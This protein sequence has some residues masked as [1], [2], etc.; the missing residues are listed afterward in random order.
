MGENFRILFDSVSRLECILQISTNNL[1]IFTNR[2]RDPFENKAL[3]LDDI[4]KCVDK[5]RYNS[6]Y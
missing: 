3:N 4:Y 2:M 6:S 1:I 5:L